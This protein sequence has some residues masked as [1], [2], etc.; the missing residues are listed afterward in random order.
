MYIHQSMSYRWPLAFSTLSGLIP[1]SVHI[2][3]FSFLSA[4][5]SYFFIVFFCGAMLS[6]HVCCVMGW[7]S[8]WLCLGRCPSLCPPFAALILGFV[9]SI[10]A[11][12][13]NGDNYRGRPGERRRW[14]LPFYRVSCML[15]Q[16]SQLHLPASPSVY[17]HFSHRVCHQRSSGVLSLLS[18]HATIH[19]DCSPSSD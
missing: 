16:A 14:V 18:Y 5:F 13:S 11:K 17:P 1:S 4:L 7:C 10:W 9:C 6:V 2:V 3:F 15:L 12:F 19:S 8:D